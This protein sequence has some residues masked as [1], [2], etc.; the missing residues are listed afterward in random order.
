MFFWVQRFGKFWVTE[1]HRLVR[2]SDFPFPQVVGDLTPGKN[3]CRGSFRSVALKTH[4]RHEIYV[5]DFGET[6]NMV[7]ARSFSRIA[8]HEQ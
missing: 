1:P 5:T 6:L 7:S 2:V 4:N 3:T 8:D